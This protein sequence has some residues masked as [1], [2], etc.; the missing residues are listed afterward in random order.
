M[1]DEQVGAVVAEV[2][3]FF[4]ALAGRSA[5]VRRTRRGVA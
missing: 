5:D 4:S 1:T 2:R 3:G